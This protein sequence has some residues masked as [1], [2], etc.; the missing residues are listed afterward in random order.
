MNPELLTI[1]LALLAAAGC[2]AG[3]AYWA[4]VWWRLHRMLPRI[5]TVED[6]AVPTPSE[7]EAESRTGEDLVTVVV[8]AHNEARVIARCAEALLAQDHRSLEIVFVLDRCTDETAAILRR[9]VGDDPRVRILE[10]D[11]CPEDWAG[12][13]HAASLGAAV[14]TGRW[15]VFTDADVRF[16]PHLVGAALRTAKAREC[17]LLSLV[18]RLETGSW[19]ERVLQPPAAVGL[20]RI[21]PLD[22]A[23]RLHR[24]RAFAN[25]QFMLF[26]RESYDAVGGHAAVKHDL[27][28]DLAFA[29][30]VNEAGIRLGVATAKDS[31]G[32]SMYPSF[33]AMRRGWRRIFIEACGRSARRM[34]RYAIRTAGAALLPV[35][36]VAAFGFA[37]HASS[38]G[39]RLA[40]AGLAAVAT[41]AV[42][43]QTFALRRI[44]RS[45]AMPRAAVLWFSIGCLVVANELRR[46]AHHLESGRPVRWG[47]R[48]YVLQSHEASTSTSPS[49]NAASDSPESPDRVAEHA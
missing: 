17:G 22:R 11:R 9:T 25:G 6:H 43:V 27:L 5:P 13:C 12:K 48:E 39:D 38:V 1:P 40:A 35:A 47:G 29:R 21:F 36:V 2:A 16:A 45:M 23:N 37:V 4:V 30:R 15:I 28:E 10:N 44:Y 41:S 26:D 46:G 8:P 31:M 3:T 42:V 24:P 19:F 14:A 7:S 32:V 18:G 34:R 33:E 20:L 49:S